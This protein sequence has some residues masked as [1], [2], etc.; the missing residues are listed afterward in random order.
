MFI[1]IGFNGIEIMDKIERPK[2]EKGKSLL[3]LLDTYTVL[4][5]ETTGLDPMFDEIIEL[6]AIRYE[7]DTEISR[8]STLVKPEERIDSY[9]TELTGITNNMVKGAPAIDVALPQF[10]SFIGNDVLVGHNVNFDINFIYDNLF[11]LT[12]TQ[13]QN[14]F[15][16]TM[17]LSRSLF[18]DFKN[19]KLITLAKNFAIAD[20]I[21][22]R[23]ESDC[24]VTALCYQY[25]KKY[26]NEHNIIISKLVNHKAT[27]KSK[28]VLAQSS[29]FD[30]S[31]S[32][33]GKT[34]VFTGILEKMVR[35]DAMQLVVDLGG[36]NGDTVTKNTN[37]LVL[38]NND[39]CKQI[40]DGKSSKQKK[41]EE[42]ILKGQDLQIISENTF[43]DIIETE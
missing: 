8:F 4:D 18:K 19:H 21:S 26:C 31:H 3:D 43:Y 5:I 24:E 36:I 1:N 14:D 16:D 29:E 33:F 15:I 32:L 13:F 20:T 34:L 28:D 2:R 9:I 30:T 11:E 27:V 39:Y 37:Y 23:G 25:I 12:D 40:K 10:I 42:L 35:K 22:H 38:G 7:N 41:A 17:R 6:S